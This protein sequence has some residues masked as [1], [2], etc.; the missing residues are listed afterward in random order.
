MIVSFTLCFAFVVK[1]QVTQPST[2]DKHYF[3]TIFT[4]FS[5]PMIHYFK[6]VPDNKDHFMCFDM[7]G[8]SNA[9]FII[10]HADAATW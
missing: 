8:M 5:Q 9:I 10:D 4:F 3:N 6:T 2:E 1:N 7:L